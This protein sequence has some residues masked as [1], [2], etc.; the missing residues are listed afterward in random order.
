MKQ[1]P[2]KL[3]IQILKAIM[4]AFQQSFV[5]ETDIFEILSKFK[6]DIDDKTNE[7]F[8]TNPPVFNVTEYLEK[9]EDEAE[10]QEEV[11]EKIIKEIIIDPF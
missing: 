5:M 11:E 6:L 4:L 7:V 8:V 1:K 9:M 10:E 2:L 3:S